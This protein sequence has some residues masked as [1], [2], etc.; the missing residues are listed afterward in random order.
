MAT[1]TITTTIPEQL[2]HH[3]Y[4][5]QD[6]MDERTQLGQIQE[7]AYKEFCDK[8]MGGADVNGWF[9]DFQE[10]I[11]HL[12]NLNF[13]IKEVRRRKQELADRNARV[14]T[15]QA[16]AYALDETNEE[17]I[18]CPRCSRPLRKDGLAKHNT[19]RVCQTIWK[20]RDSVA[21]RPELVR[22]ARQHAVYI[23]DHIHDHYIPDVDT[24][25]EP[26]EHDG[27]LLA[28]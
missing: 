8:M 2:L 20:G 18:I 7:G 10:I 25:E 14:T 23:K 13:E 21:V 19:T 11:H 24:D 26:D 9:K 16:L 1:H 5:L 27:F 17:F 3:L 12:K 6:F 22:V 15:A 28:D 4:A